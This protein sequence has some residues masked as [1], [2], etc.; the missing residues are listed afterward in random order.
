[1]KIKLFIILLVFCTCKKINYFPDHPIYDKTGLLLAHRGGRNAVY[2]ENSLEGIKAAL[3]HKDG[4]EVDVQISKSEGIW[5]SHSADVQDCFGSIGCFPETKDDR[6]K[7]ITTCNGVDFS[8]TMLEDVFQFIHDS[9][10]SAWV[11]I[12]LKGW[13]PCSGNSLDIEGMMRREAEIILDMAKKYQLFDQ[14]LV[15]TETSSVLLYLQKKYSGVHLYQNVYGD[16]ERGMLICLNY[17]FA[18]LSYKMNVGDEIDKEKMDMLHRKGL[19]LMAWNLH[20]ISDAKRLQEIGVDYI[21]V[22]LK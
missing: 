22:D 15:E 16:F 21:Q 8:Y 2:R 5:L 11:A 9:F 10:P 17:G 6:I 12:D 1:M 20:D 14:V 18:G 19:K 13:V 4:I 3:K 7:A